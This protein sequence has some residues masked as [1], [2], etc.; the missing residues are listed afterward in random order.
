MTKQQRECINE[1][2]KSLQ[3]ARKWLDQA[4]Y[5]SDG[6]MDESSLKNT[7][8]GYEMICSVIDKIE[9]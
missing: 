5:Y 3:N 2:V 6:V 1:A 8:E 7:R 4:M 9:K